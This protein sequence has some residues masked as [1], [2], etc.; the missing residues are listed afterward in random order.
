VLL[1]LPAEQV[2]RF[3]DRPKPPDWLERYRPFAE[4]RSRSAGDPADRA[5]FCREDRPGGLTKSSH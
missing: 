3:R 1:A 5:R 4:G 2:A